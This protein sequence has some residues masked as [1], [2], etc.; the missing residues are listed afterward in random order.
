MPTACGWAAE[1][2]PTIDIDGQ[3]AHD[4]AER[5]LSKPI[6]PKAS[7]TDRI[8][9]WIDEILHRLTAG[10]ADLPGGWLALVVLGLL[11]VAAVFAAVRVARRTMGRSAHA[12]L[13][14]AGVRSA[15]E[16]RA[17]AELAAARGDWSTAIRQRVRAIGRHLEEDGVLNAVPGR[18]AGELARE[19]GRALPDLASEI[20]TAADLFNEVTYGGQPG[21]EVGYRAVAA[22]D[23]RLIAT[24]ATASVSPR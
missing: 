14:G 11:A 22:V 19:A 13:Y 20:G 9:E 2:M 3:T 12:G 5:E 21:S 7:L 8:A 10:A 16:H 18:T 6:Y 24:P 1:A 15:A 23:D 17:Q 4:A